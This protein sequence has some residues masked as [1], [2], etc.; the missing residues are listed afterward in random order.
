MVIN[1]VNSWK[2]RPD[3]VTKIPNLFLA[4]D[5]VK[6][7]TDLATMEAANEAAR[8]AVNGIIEASG[9]AAKK[10]KVWELKEPLIFAP[11]KWYDKQVYARNKESKVSVPGWLKILMIPWIVVGIT[12]FIMKILIFRLLAIKPH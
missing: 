7:N 4:A 11:L 2:D 3:A 10:C 6:T 8:R 1:T 5:Y 9:S 12:Y